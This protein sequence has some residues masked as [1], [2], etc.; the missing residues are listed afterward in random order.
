MWNKLCVLLAFLLLGMLVWVL[1]IWPIIAEMVEE[2]I[3]RPCET[4]SSDGSNQG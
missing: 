1:L 3:R 2:N 4:W